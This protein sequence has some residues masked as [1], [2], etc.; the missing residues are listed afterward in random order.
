MLAHFKESCDKSI[1]FFKKQRHYFAENVQYNQSYD[2]SSCNVW[3]WQLH[4]KEWWAMKNWWLWTVVLDKTLES[5]FKYKEIK[6]VNPEGNQSWIFIGR[7]DAEA[8]TSVVWPPDLKKWLIWKD[9]DPGKDWRQEEKRTTED[10]MVGWHHRCDGLEFEQT[11]VI[12]DGQG[13]QFCCC[14]WDCKKSDTTELLNWESHA[15][16]INNTEKSPVLFTQF[17]QWKKHVQNDLHYLNQGIDIN[18]VKI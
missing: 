5:P 6:P 18:T 15:V 9:P 7:T 14:P 10:E 8:E 17:P 16:V 3:M 2:F 12:G 13:S 4:H 1:Q 11:L